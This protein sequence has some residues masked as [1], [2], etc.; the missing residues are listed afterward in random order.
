MQWI[1]DPAMVTKHSLMQYWS[2][3]HRES[4]ESTNTGVKYNYMVEE[5]LKLQLRKAQTYL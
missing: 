3:G 1:V 4:R 2:V 5:V